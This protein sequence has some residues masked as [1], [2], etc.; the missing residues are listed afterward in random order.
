MTLT[1]RLAIEKMGEISPHYIRSCIMHSRH[2]TS[3][4]DILGT[5]A[6]QYILRNIAEAF[7]CTTEQ[8]IFSGVLRG[9]SL[10][11]VPTNTS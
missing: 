7:V 1:E 9:R 5:Y 10:T 11:S 2:F 8:Y 3:E 4:C 6:A